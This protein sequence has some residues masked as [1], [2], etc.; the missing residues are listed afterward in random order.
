[1]GNELA[2]PAAAQRRGD[3]DLDAEL[4]GPMGLALADAFDF[5]RVQRID[6]PP[7]LM[8]VLLAHPA[9]QHE[10]TGEEIFQRRL[11]L[12]LA[13]NVANDPAEKG[14]DRFQRPIGPLELLGVGVALMGNER[15][16][17]HP[18]VGLA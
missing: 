9:R 4:V 8:L 14:S 3:R 16:L 15:P 1:M 7:A 2:A 6:L 11:A 17:A 18:L 5:G 10:R 12:D 13:H